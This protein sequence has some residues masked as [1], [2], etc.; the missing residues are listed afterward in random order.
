MWQRSTHVD[1]T[2]ELAAVAMGQ[3]AAELIITNGILANVH[4]GEFLPQTDI[5]IYK[6]LIALVGDAT[7]VLRDEQ[8]QLVDAG[9]RYL[10]PGFID[11]HLHVESSMVDVRRYAEAVLPHGTTAIVPD[12]HE[13]ANV[14]GL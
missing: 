12:P 4:T 7:H 2:R 9:G 1:W 8:T 13:I 5:A 10:V 14:F 3:Q 11:T 6:G